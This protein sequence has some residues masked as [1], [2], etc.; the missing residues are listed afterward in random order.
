MALTLLIGV[1]LGITT[2]G[3]VP[4]EDIH[5][6]ATLSGTLE[7]PDGDP[8]QN[9]SVYASWLAAYS[10]LLQ[11]NLDPNGHYEIIVTNDTYYSTSATLEPDYYLTFFEY[12]QDPTTGLTA[13]GGSLAQNGVVDIYT[14][15]QVDSSTDRDLG[16]IQLPVGHPVRFKVERPDGTPVDR[17]NISVYHTVDGPNTGVGFTNV[18]INDRGYATFRATDST[19][20]EL[21]GTITVEAQSTVPSTEQTTQRTLEI[22]DTIDEVVLTLSSESEPTLNIA[23]PYIVSK[24]MFQTEGFT[25]HVW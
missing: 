15:A 4:G 12:D 17:A 6:N 5:V 14:F 3:P 2:I 20:I 8:P 22:N 16:R 21:N 19:F 10:D 24:P 9:G 25:T 13:D 1:S 23:I 7:T 18:S 11:T